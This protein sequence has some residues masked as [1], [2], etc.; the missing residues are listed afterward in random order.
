MFVI[1]SFFNYTQEMSVMK[2]VVLNLSTRRQGDKKTYTR[3]LAK[4][5]SASIHLPAR[6]FEPHDELN[7]S[8]P[9]SIALVCSVRTSP[10]NILSQAKAV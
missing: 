7:V 10:K 9:G 8:K 1:L 5:K 4:P 2:Q 3:D 6:S